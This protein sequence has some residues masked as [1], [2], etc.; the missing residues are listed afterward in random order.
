MSV[1]FDFGYGLCIVG[2][3]LLVWALFVGLILISFDAEERKK[4]GYAPL[5]III[6]IGFVVLGVSIILIRIA[7]DY[8][9][10][11]L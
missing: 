4:Y 2:L 8:M 9:A 3:T 7:C 6:P 10:G 1:W 5:I 11:A